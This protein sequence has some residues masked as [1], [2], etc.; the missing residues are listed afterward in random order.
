MPSTLRASDA[1]SGSKQPQAQG[2]RGECTDETRQ[3]SGQSL[4][5]ERH[6]RWPEPRLPDVGEERR[7]DHQSGGFSRRYDQAEQPDRDR[8]QALAQHA[9]DEAGEHEG[10]PREGDDE[11]SFRHGDLQCLAAHQARL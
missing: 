4:P 1:A 5:N 10:E 11:T 2:G 3:Q 6:Q 9:F 7:D 8:R